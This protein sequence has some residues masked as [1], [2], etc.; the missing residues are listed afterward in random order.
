MLLINRGDFGS[1][2]GWG[3]AHSTIWKYNSEMLAQQPPTAQNYAISN[4]GNFRTSVYFPGR[5]VAPSIS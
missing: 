1:S 4:A 5:V 2:H 3:T